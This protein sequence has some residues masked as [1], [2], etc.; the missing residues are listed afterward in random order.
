MT[1][2]DLL[3][4][5]LPLVIGIAVFIRSGHKFYSTTAVLLTGLAMVIYLTDMKPFW[6][7]MIAYIALWAV[8]FIIPKRRAN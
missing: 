6:L 3:Y 5:F 8:I 2:A 4:F 1:S 7:T